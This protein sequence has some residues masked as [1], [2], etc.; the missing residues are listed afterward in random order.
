MAEKYPMDPITLRIDGV[1]WTYW[2]TV[3]ITRAVDAV[4]G[5]F[6]LGLVERWG[7]SQSGMQSLPIAA[8]QSCEVLIGSDQVIKGYIDKVSSAF[9]HA[10]HVITVTGRDASADLV[11][12]AAVH[13]PGQWSGLT[14]AA[15]AQILASPF[16]VPVRAEGDVGAALPT[17]KLEP[18]EKAFDA[19]ERALNQRECFACP[20]G[21]GGMVILKIG[22]RTSQGNLKQGVNVKE[23]SLDCDISKRHSVYIVQA[24]KPGNDNEYGV[25][26][27]AVTSS[28]KDDAVTRYRP[29]LIKAENSADSGTARQR[30]A[31]EKTV[32]AGRSVTARVV[33]QGFRQLGVGSEQRGPLWEINSMTEVD[34]PYLRLQ[35]RLLISKIVFK[36]S[37]QSGSTTELELRDPAAFTPEPKKLKGTGAGGSKANL[38]VER[39]MDIQTRLASDANKAN[40]GVKK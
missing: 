20:D 3:E 26:A 14:C 10:G 12:C 25:A 29:M 2:Q 8:G 15:L 34:I 35:Q 6:S 37:I 39:E 9:S 24:Q 7:D 32:R 4:A 16:G 5:S 21:K 38:T 1:D 30:A 22:S 18:A 33:V 11:D 40:K 36:R 23:A 17:F 19:L 13:K 28:I 27:C 31:W